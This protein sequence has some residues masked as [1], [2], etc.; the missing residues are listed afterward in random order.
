MDRFIIRL[1]W[2]ILIIAGDKH[3]WNLVSEVWLTLIRS[4]EFLCEG[5]CNYIVISYLSAR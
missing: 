3:K 5:K 1:V 4:V 2:N